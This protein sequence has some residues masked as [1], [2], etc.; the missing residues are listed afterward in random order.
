MMPLHATSEAWAEWWRRLD[1]LKAALG[2]LATNVSSARL[3]EDARDVVQLYFRQV[4]GQIEA[5]GIEPEKRS[6]DPLCPFHMIC[7]VRLQQR[8]GFA[9]SFIE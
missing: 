8:N 1:A 3:R 5:L 2:R 4:R 6:V 9:P 7:T